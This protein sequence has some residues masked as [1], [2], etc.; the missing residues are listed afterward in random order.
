MI[1]QLRELQYREATNYLSIISNSQ[2]YIANRSIK[3][4]L[5][6]ARMFQVLHLHEAINE[7]NN[8]Y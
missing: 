3:L 5:Q 7:Y 2:V 6:G 4:F 1:L 8:D